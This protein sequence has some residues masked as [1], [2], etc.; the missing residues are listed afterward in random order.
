MKVNEENGNNSADSITIT[1]HL[2]SSKKCKAEIIISDSDNE[3]AN[4]FPGNTDK[5]PKSEQTNEQQNENPNETNSCIQCKYI[6]NWI[7]TSY[8]DICIAHRD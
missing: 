7:C 6:L 8:T 5:E 1:H 3:L 2:E 4:A